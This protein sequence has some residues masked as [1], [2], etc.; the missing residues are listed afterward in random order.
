VKKRKGYVEYDFNGEKVRIPIDPDHK[1]LPRAGFIGAGGFLLG[2]ETNPTDKS[3]A[4]WYEAQDQ[5]DEMAKARGTEEGGKVRAQQKQLEAQKIAEWLHP[6]LTRAHAHLVGDGHK[7]IGWKKLM[8]EAKL[9][10]K[11]EDTRKGKI[12]ER[13]VKD[14]LAK[15]PNPQ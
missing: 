8:D 10:L 4:E 1:S 11:T 9:H 13:R 2:T 6:L 15:Q 14:W 7:K 5:L 12:T 3:K